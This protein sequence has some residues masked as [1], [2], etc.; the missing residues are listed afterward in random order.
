MRFNA[1]E[2]SLPTCVLYTGDNLMYPLKVHRIVKDCWD[3]WLKSSQIL[4]TNS[5]L[6]FSRVKADAAINNICCGS[7]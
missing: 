3:F 7:I 5:L 1:H 2:C 4:Q 6:L